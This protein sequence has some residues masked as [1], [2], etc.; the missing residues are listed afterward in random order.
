MNDTILPT[1]DFFFIFSSFESDGDESDCLPLVMNGCISAL[2]VLDLS[3]CRSD[4]VSQW[5]EVEQF[6]FNLVT[7][8]N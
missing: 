6:S 4:I 5:L 3:V 2:G 8:A 1:F 7:I